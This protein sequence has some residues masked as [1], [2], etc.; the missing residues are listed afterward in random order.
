MVSP[1]GNGLSS[2]ALLAFVLPRSFRFGDYHAGPV[3]HGTRLSAAALAFLRGG[4]D[5][6]LSKQPQVPALVA[7]E[8]RQTGGCRHETRSPMSVT[9]LRLMSWKPPYSI[10]G[11]ATTSRAKAMCMRASAFSLNISADRTVRVSHVRGG[12]S[13]HLSS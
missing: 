7:G 3:F 6:L 13:R 4:T 10:A 9:G 5:M 12:G 11:L 1:A 8:P 2:V